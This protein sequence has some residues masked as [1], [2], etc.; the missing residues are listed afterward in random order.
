MILIFNLAAIGMTLVFGLGVLLANPTRSLNRAFFLL[1]AIVA[2]WLIGLTWLTTPNN[3]DAGLSLRVTCAIG[4]FFPCLLWI[5]KNCAKGE[6]FDWQ[7]IQRSWPWFLGGLVL[8][9]D[10]FTGYFIPAESTQ[11]HPLRG[12][13]W[14]AYSIILGI[15]F[16][17]LLVQTAFDIRKLQ[18]IHRVELQT[19][20]IGGAAVGLFGV[21]FTAIGPLM[22]LH[23]LP[24]TALPTLIVGF[25]TITAWAITTQKVFDARHLFQAGLRRLVL[26]LMVGLILTIGIYVGLPI[27][28]APLVILICTILMGFV[29]QQ[30][31]QRIWRA[32]Q[33]GGD[34][35]IAATRNAILVASREALDL[36]A[37]EKRFCKILNNWGR[38]EHTYIL[39]GSLT[40]YSSGALELPNASRALTELTATGWATPE[41]LQRQRPTA[42]RSE[43]ELF[44]RQH[45]L[46]V[47]VAGPSGT[48]IYPIIIAQEI[49]HDRRP[50]VW[51]EVQLLQ[52][53]SS[54]IEG[55][56]SRAGLSQH[57][58]DAEQLVTAGLLGANL[59][60]EIRNPLVTIKL[61][62]QSAKD[63]FYEPDF[64]RLFIDIVPGELERI[65][66][67]VDGLLDLG[68]P[69]HP[70]FEPVRLNEIVA[71]SLKLVQS[72]ADKE[73]VTMTCALEAAPDELS[74]DNA[75][76]RQVVLNLLMNAIEA[77]SPVE[78]NRAVALRTASDAKSVVLEVADNGPGVP[79]EVRQ[80][81]F[82]PFTT[83][84]KTSGIGLGLAITAEIVR[85]H[86][87]Q[88]I[89][90]DDGRAGTT[91]RVT[92]PC[93]QPSS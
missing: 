55:A 64:R 3:P 67:L 71:N 34:R 16:L 25:Y 66:G 10:A 30:M 43:V 58:R 38:T 89:L 19:L 5:V 90:L 82:R 46:G 12:W 24:R 18:G 79:L 74:A 35:E 20:L 57:A 31:N 68:R 61:I 80:R 84:N 83:S 8:A 22:G 41:S 49:R 85:S 45:R 87:G 52:E 33:F 92:L 32:T 17:L 48:G 81:L 78:G 54:V 69:R 75:S 70:K 44:M 28:S 6:S 77:V 36:H 47:M 93:Q 60:H 56:F 76:L 40:G 65:E 59:A 39:S 27:L 42:A 15:Q 72:K 7:A 53:W 86:H 50:F 63:R 21:T 29:L 14:S 51:P 9:V 13:G 23:S 62:V 11:Q 37:L 4:A 91:F 88:I 1:S 2:I 73:K 26:L